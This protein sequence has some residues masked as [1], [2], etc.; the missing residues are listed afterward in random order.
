[1]RKTARVFKRILFISLSAIMICFS[2]CGIDSEYLP[3][4]EVLDGYADL[5]EVALEKS[6]FSTLENMQTKHYGYGKFDDY[7]M[8]HQN[9][10]ALPDYTLGLRSLAEEI[11][12]DGSNL[13]DYAEALMRDYGFKADISK[14]SG[15]TEHTDLNKALVEFYK[16]CGSTAASVK[17]LPKLSKKV[18]EALAKFLS[19][20]AYAIKLNK[21][22][23]SKVNMLEYANLERFDFAYPARDDVEDITA[24]YLC[25]SKTDEEK[26]LYSGLIML[27]ATAELTKTLEKVKTVTA[28]NTSAAIPTPAG[29]I[30][31]GTSGDDVY[32]SPKAFL[33][34]E[35]GGNDVYN[36]AVA[37]STSR[38]NLISVVIDLKG[39]DLYTAD[40]YIG[41]TQGSGVLGTGIL[42]D[43]SGDD[44]YEA[45]RLA[46]GNAVVGT[47]VLFDKQGND[48]YKSS[49][50]SQASANYGLAL[51]VDMGGDDSYDSVAFSQGFANNRSMAFL[52]NSG[53][54]DSYTVTQLTDDEWRVFGYELYPNV[55]GN[56]SQ[57]CG[58]GNRSHWPTDEKG[59]AGGLAGL[60]DLGSGNDL[61]T[62]GIWV[63]G[64]GYWSGI[65]LLVDAG[66]NDIYDSRHYCQASVAHFGIAALIDMGNGNDL[67]TYTAEGDDVRMSGGMGYAFDRGVA[68]MIDEAGNDCYEIQHIGLGS[69]ISL[70]DDKG[71]Y[72]QD[73]IYSFFIDADGEDIY[74][75]SH[76]KES[77]GYG[78]GG[79]FIDG[80]N[81]FDIY[82]NGGR[83]TNNNLRSYYGGVIYDYTAKEDSSPS[84]VIFWE[85][86]KIKY[87]YIK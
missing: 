10:L 32:T 19:Q 51:S 67:H 35:P 48:V 85:R 86:A 72:E 43:M 82:Y 87:G 71:I 18:S 42:M 20:A 65:G 47:G 59:L 6:G 64:V 29:D 4:Y 36:G 60:L 1:M 14:E 58:A 30:L 28:D 33:I 45:Y 13:A 12:G 55:N 73:Y 62:G 53:G 79:F 24:A 23:I 41:A 22:E 81:D 2:G 66:G 78:R 9:P 27:R 76:S 31:L 15:Y 34:L 3:N 40:K 17:E 25:H 84:A 57:G 52:I 83:L 63:M 37:A 21:E 16:A 68:M 46:Q 54:S 61:Y 50:S 8:L 80:G 77:Y 56:W 44:C 5:F 69:A 70:Y 39:N 49:L 75:K 38:E 11:K 74:N 26:I 7:S